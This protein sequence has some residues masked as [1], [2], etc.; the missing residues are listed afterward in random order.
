MDLEQPNRDLFARNN[1]LTMMR[2]IVQLGGPLNKDDFGASE[3]WTSVRINS[4]RQEQLDFVREF[5]MELME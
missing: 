4:E 2:T 5:L 1:D 3:Q